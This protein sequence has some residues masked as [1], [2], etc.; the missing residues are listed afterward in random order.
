MRKNA[1]I[2]ESK[3]IQLLSE[4][5]MSRKSSARNILGQFATPSPLSNDIVKYAKILLS[6]AKD[7]HFLDP[8]IGTGTF[9][10]SLIQNFSP[11]KLKSAQGFDID[12]E[13]GDVAKLLYKA[14][15]LNVI[16]KD[17]TTA[18]PIP[19]YNLV[20]CNPP[21]VRHHH[22]EQSEKLRLQKL[23]QSKGLK[24]SG[25]SGLYCYFILQTHEWMAENGIAAWLIPSEFMDVNY[26]SVIR[27]YLTEEVTLLHIHRFDPKDVQFD[28]A[29]VSSAIV[30]F[31]KRKPT[32]NHLVNFSFGGALQSPKISKLIS[33]KDLAKEHKWT[34]FPN[35]E[36]REITN[37]LKLGDLFKITRGLA[38]GN[39]SFFIL[40]ENEITKRNLPIEVFTPILPSSKYIPNDVIESDKNR[41]PVLSKKLFLLNVRLPENEI[42]LKYPAL[43]KYLHEGVQKE[44][45]L[46]YIN[47]HRTFWYLQESR[48]APP[49]FCTYLGRTDVPEKTPFRFILNKSNAVATNSYLLLYPTLLL[50]KYFNEYSLSIDTIWNYLRKIPH[51]ELLGEGRVYGGG[52]HKLE[53]KELAKVPIRDLNAFLKNLLGTEKK[54]LLKEL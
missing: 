23:A 53:P 51:H 46:S 7:I 16:I 15:G 42:K 1:S 17:F 32:P 43:S 40:D 37:E 27:K 30:W 44:F 28:D 50:Q 19:K 9:F 24:V 22:L 45:H 14:S 47:S 33:I 52:L 29:T 49:I 10:S 48:N 41:N 12:K 34:R 11:S 39:N 21:Y 54:S 25:L 6:K 4:L 35:N 38:T 2:L 31:K 8:A 13:Y 18:K 26:G 20:I 3:R 5:D 36:V